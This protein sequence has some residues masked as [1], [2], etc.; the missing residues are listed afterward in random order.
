[1][2]SEKPTLLQMWNAFSDRFGLKTEEVTSIKDDQIILVK[3]EISSI[4]FTF[5]YEGHFERTLAERGMKLLRQRGTVGV[6]T[7]LEIA[8]LDYNPG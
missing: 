2:S 6:F 4:Q 1:M 5:D 3:V 7:A 8:R